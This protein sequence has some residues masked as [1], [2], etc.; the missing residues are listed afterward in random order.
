MVS[1]CSSQKSSRKCKWSQVTELAMLKIKSKVSAWHTEFFLNTALLALQP[2]FLSHLLSLQSIAPSR[3]CPGL[4]TVPSAWQ[5]SLYIQ[6][7][8]NSYSFSRSHLL[9]QFLIL[10]PFLDSLCWGLGLLFFLCALLPC[11]TSCLLALLEYHIH[12]LNLR[13]W[14]TERAQQMFGKWVKYRNHT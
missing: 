6:S 5:A 7:L 10:S 1:A 3:Q 4:I 12:Y 14:H 13:A 9:W 11:S 8:L 2:H